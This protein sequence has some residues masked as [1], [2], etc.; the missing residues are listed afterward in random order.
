MHNFLEPI[1]AGIL[2]F[3]IFLGMASPVL[4]IGFFYYLKKRLEHKQIMAAIEKGLPFSNIKP[5]KH[6]GSAW[7]KNLTAGIAMLIIA[8]GL[9]YFI[10]IVRRCDYD[11]SL[12]HFLIVVIFFAFGI[13][14]VIRGLLQRNAEKKIPVPTPG[15][16]DSP[17]S[18][19]P[20]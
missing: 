3:L 6:L 14:R 7:I 9:A 13:A 4:V 10:Y 17:N 1:A 12:G 8:A 15:N 2:V 16:S 11:H 18:D 19:L 20:S 5:P